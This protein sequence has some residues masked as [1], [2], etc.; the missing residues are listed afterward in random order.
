ME[1]LDQTNTAMR[2]YERDNHLNLRPLFTL[3]EL[4]TLLG[5]LLYMIL[6]DKGEYANYWGSQIEDRLLRGSS[7]GLDNVMSLVRFNLLRKSFCSRAIHNT[8]LPVPPVTAAESA[9]ARVTDAEIRAFG[10]DARDR[11]DPV[12]AEPNATSVLLPGRVIEPP[13]TNIVDGT[14]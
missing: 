14:P 7:V 9:G 6:V 1:V 12:E 8:V 2:Y 10:I 4:M 13:E 5:L 3:Q 11:A